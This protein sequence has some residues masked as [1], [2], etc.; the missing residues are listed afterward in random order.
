MMLTLR[1]FG[2]PSLEGGGQSTEEGQD[3]A[4][5][6]SI[7]HM[8]KRFALLAYLA[9]AS[10]PGHHRRDTLL[11][12]LWSDLDQRRARAALNRTLYDLRQA[13]GDGVVVSL[14]N[15]HVGLDWERV[16]C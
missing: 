6:P 11:G 15:D 9:S 8:P 10:P 3:G 12:L 4:S 1:L 14:G 13:L 2:T 16:W 7:L 5:T